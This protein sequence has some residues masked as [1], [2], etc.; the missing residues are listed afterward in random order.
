MTRSRDRLHAGTGKAHSHSK[1]A[2]PRVPVP[3]SVDGGNQVG[4]AIGDE[5]AEQR[6]PGSITTRHARVEGVPARAQWVRRWRLF[7]RLSASPPGGVLLVCGPAGSGKTVLLRSWVEAEGLGERVAWVEVERGEQDA[8]RF[9]LSVID[10]L[11]DAGGGEDLVARVEPTPDFRGEAVVKRLLSDLDSLAEPTVLVI[12]D[13]HEL[14]SA[15]ARAS[16]ELLLDRVPAKLRVALA[17]RV[18]PPL[19]LHRLRLAGELTEIR[20][21]DLPFSP[22]ETGELLEASG[23]VLSNEAVALLHQRTEGWVAALRLAAIS[24]TEHPDPERFVSEFCGSER[25]VAGYLVAEVMERQPPEVRELLLRTS[26]LDRVSGPLGDFLTGASCSERI[27]QEL[28]D[29]NA[30]V[31]S[32]DAGR[33]WFRYHHLFADFL[34]LELRRTDPASIETLHGKAAA[35]YEEHAHPVDAIRHAQAARDWSYAARLLGEYYVGLILDGRLATVHGLLAA[36]PL[37]ALDENAELPIALASARVFEGRFEDAASFVDL[38]ARRSAT[39]AEEQRWRF[40]LRLANVRLWVARLRG[41]LSTALEA[42]ESVEAALA[43]RPPGEIASITELRATAFMNLGITELW[44]LR[45]VDARSHLEEALALA[46]RAERPYQ[47]ITC[48]AHLG[49]ASVFGGEPIPDGVKL[50][51]EAIA[52]AGEHG[53]DDDPVIAPALAIGGLELVWLGRFEE[54]ERWLERAQQVLAPELQGMTEVVTQQAI[55]LLRFA[56]AQLGEAVVAFRA[57]ERLKARLS[58]GATTIDPRSGLLRVHARMGDIAAA[59]AVLA[60]VSDEERGRAAMRVGEAA[61]HL[62]EDSPE[63]ALKV[64]APVLEGAEDAVRLQPDLIEALLFDAVALEE[65][66][67]TRAGKQ[68]LERALDLAEPDGILLPF[69]LAPVRELLER[70]PRH[71]TAHAALLSEILDVLTGS[72]ARPAGEGAALWEELSEAELRVLRFLPSNLKAPE[73]AAELSVS[74]NTVRT[75]LRHIYSKLDAHSRREAVDRA[76]ELG[77]VSPRG[78]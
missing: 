74:P 77:L 30:F 39:V 66:G 13:L 2:S 17:S 7:E 55:G 56:R 18:E 1:F 16:L 59:H 21:P 78:R 20:G 26:I 58:R 23:I 62:A 71:K 14:D 51:E 28:E 48:I 61:V 27:L 41:E 53:W 57:A 65:L 60:E 29:A 46:R 33:S 5:P 67:D 25:N 15:E 68:S 3:A 36:F 12:D 52:I 34:Q 47:E 54:A 24:L 8:Q 72:S 37:E 22:A 9:W 64:L 4:L 32:L 35:W 75:H 76:R 45:V 40:E 50:A 49:L 70:H 6:P 42:M 11:A 43:A 10:A 31:T 44:A 69:A 63:Q 73:I 38:A 19:G